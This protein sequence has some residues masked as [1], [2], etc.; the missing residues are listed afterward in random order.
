MSLVTLVEP[1]KKVHAAQEWLL[2]SCPLSFLWAKKKLTQYCCRV[3]CPMLVDS[4]R[5]RF[6]DLEKLLSVST[7]GLSQK[8]VHVK[9]L[10]VRQESRAQ[11]TERMGRRKNKAIRHECAVCYQSQW[12]KRVVLC[13]SNQGGSVHAT[14]KTCLNRWYT[15]DPRKRNLCPICFK[16]LELKQ[17]DIKFGSTSAV[18]TSVEPIDILTQQWLLRNTKRCPN[19]RTAIQKNGG[20]NRLTCRCGAPLCYLCGR[21]LYQCTCSVFKMVTGMTIQEALENILLLIVVTFILM[22]THRFEQYLGVTHI[23]SGS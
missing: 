16:A 2:F 19:C 4:S 10:R 13:R 12:Q 3:L 21:G 1:T 6:N 5:K 14:C 8:K 9:I 7:D 20:C 18:M 17:N 11:D 23:I 15:T 22:L